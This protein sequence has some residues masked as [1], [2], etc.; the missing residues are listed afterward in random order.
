MVETMNIYELS[1]SEVK[2]LQ[3]FFEL[4]D[5]AIEA[6]KIIQAQFSSAFGIG[7]TEI[8]VYDIN[9][10]GGDYVA[11]A[12]LTIDGIWKFT[13]YWGGCNKWELD[14]SSEDS[15]FQFLKKAYLKGKKNEHDD[16]LTPVRHF[17]YFIAEEEKKMNKD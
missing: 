5:E 7:K 17:R 12:V 15:I 3:M 4:A 13:D 2:D 1:V 9:Q 14:C 8:M 6:S 10:C 11:N 16:Y